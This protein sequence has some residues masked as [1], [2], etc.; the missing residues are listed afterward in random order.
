MNCRE[1]R[2]RVWRYLDHEVDQ[3]LRRR[4]EDHLAACAGCARYFAREQ[5]LEAALTERLAAGQAT[6]AMWER[7]LSRAG[8]KAAAATRLRRLVVVGLVAAAVL[9]LTAVGL[10]IAQPAH[11]SELARV[12]A[13]WH[14]RLLAGTVRPDMASTSD[15]EVDRYLKTKVPFRVHCPPRT[16]VDFAVK[17]AGVCTLKGQ[18][19]AAYIFGRVEQVPVS[20]LVLDRASLNAFPRDRTR[21][22]DSGRAQCRE[23]DLQMVY[24]IIHENVVVVIG[25]APLES[26]EKLLSAYGTYPDG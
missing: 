13:D 4:I 19:Q 12:A 10:R 26:L 22:E 25:A 24:G 15:E 18:R 14:Q 11:S 17:G 20:I 9:L 3:E 8:V 6:P 23:A 7:V 21:L 2:Q 1:T 5:R 16:D